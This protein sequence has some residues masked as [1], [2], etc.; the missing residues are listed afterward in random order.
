M[1]FEKTKRAVVE[2][3]EASESDEG[4]SELS[5]ITPQVSTVRA[6]A[7]VSEN[8]ALGRQVTATSFDTYSVSSLTAA[9]GSITSVSQQELPARPMSCRALVDFNRSLAKGVRDA[10]ALPYAV[11]IK[12]IDDIA[13]DLVKGQQLMDDVYRVLESVGNSLQSIEREADE[14]RAQCRSALPLVSHSQIR[15]PKPPTSSS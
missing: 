13:L 3:G 9:S 1:S 15:I 6:A 10:A 14:L 7:S 12:E 4:E 2:A 5:R 8:P 11:A